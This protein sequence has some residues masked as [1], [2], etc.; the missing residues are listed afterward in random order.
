MKEY[1]SEGICSHGMYYCLLLIWL[2]GVDGIAMMIDGFALS[3]N[4]LFH[5]YIFYRTLSTAV[6]LMFKLNVNVLNSSIDVKLK[7]N[8]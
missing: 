2:R 6:A 5:T 7:F 4:S 3:L 8:L 1:F